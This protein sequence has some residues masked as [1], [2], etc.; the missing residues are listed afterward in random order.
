MDNDYRRIETAIRYLDDHVH[1]QPG[2]EDIARQVHLSPYHFQR[3]FSRWAG[4]SPKRFLQFLTLEHAKRLL[5][6]PGTQ[7]DAAYGSGLSSPSRLH[8]LFVSVD[9]V[10]PGQYQALGAGLEIYY[11]LHSSPF[12]DCLLSVTERGLC[13]L[14]FL[15][16]A[17][18]GTAL[19]DLR[20]HWPQAR[21][22][23]DRGR[24]AA[25][26][27]RIFS[28]PEDRQRRPLPLLLKGTNFQIKVWEALL[29]IPPAA[30]TSYRLLAAAVGNPAASRAVG[31]AV[32]ANPIAY[33]IPC[34]RVILS[35]GAFGNYRYGTVRKKAILAWEQA[36]FYTHQ[37]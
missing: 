3:L 12:G 13:G 37:V 20:R 30:V 21:L 24:T 11:G 25:V 17:G 36:R 16:E 2:L 1:E 31:S 34:H 28:I 9:A 32:G 35:T 7:L 4:V 19:Q 22:L 23:E 29:R 6:Q 14:S 5:R 27:Q 18:P 33:L 10:T 26:I 15:D 8:D